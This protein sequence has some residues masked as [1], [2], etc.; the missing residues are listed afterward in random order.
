M[1]PA[2][3]RTALPGLLAG[4]FAALV[5]GLLIAFPTKA[6]P[7]SPPPQQT[8]PTLAQRWHQGAENFIDRMGFWMA[9]LAP[10]CRLPAPARF[11]EEHGENYALSLGLGSALIK[12]GL[13]QCD[14]QGLPAYLESSHPRNVPLYERH[15]FRVVSQTPERFFMEL[16]V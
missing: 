16:H 2:K 1:A 14:A 11:Y 12:H 15:G 10:S 6:Q 8:Q 4:H 3:P 5:A 9:P 7:S 13:R